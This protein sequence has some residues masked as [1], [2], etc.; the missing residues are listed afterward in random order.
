VYVYDNPLYWSD[1]YG[2]GKIERVKKAIQTA[3]IF[4]G[5]CQG[6]HN[7]TNGVPPERIPSPSRED[8]EKI[9]QV[10]DPKN[11]RKDPGGSDT[12]SICVPDEI[13][14]TQEV[15]EKSCLAGD[16]LSCKAYE[17]STGQSIADPENPMCYKVGLCI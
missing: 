2:L 13:S 10:R 12:K 11:T 8:V 1:E 14:A 5:I 6:A 16:V 4:V 9:E 15:L 17:L 7:V 3:C